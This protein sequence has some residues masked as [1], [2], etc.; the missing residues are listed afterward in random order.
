M[1]LLT[2]RQR[3]NFGIGWSNLLLQQIVL[4]FV[5]ETSM[6]FLWGCEKS[7]G[8]EPS[9]SRPKFLHNFMSKMA[10]M[11]LGY[12]GPCFTWRGRAC[13]G[14]L[15]QEPLDRGL[16]NYEWQTAWPNT[17]VYH[18]TVVGFDH[19]PLI[20]NCGPRSRRSK[21]PFKFEANWAREE[22]SYRLVEKCWSDTFDRPWVKRWRYKLNQCKTQLKIWSKEKFKNNEEIDCLMEQLHFMQDNWEMNYQDMK[23]ITHKI[24]EL[25]GRNECYWKQ[26]SRIKWLNEWDSN[27]SYFY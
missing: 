24:N 11:D 9:H 22:E 3:M 18:E 27:T 23:V 20:V 26:W 8:S 14:D 16:V 2:R 13:N 4:G 10:L 15:V 1:G 5:E 17:I 25:W 12:V 7:G 19:C 21:R 6:N